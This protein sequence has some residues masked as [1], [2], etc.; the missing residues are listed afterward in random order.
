MIFEKGMI[1]CLLGSFTKIG[2]KNVVL[3]RF[4]ILDLY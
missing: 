4:V 3:H 1:N 2:N